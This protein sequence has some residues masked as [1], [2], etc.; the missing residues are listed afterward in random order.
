LEDSEKEGYTDF[1]HW[2]P[3]GD[4]FAIANKMMFVNTILRR[5]CIRKSCKTFSWFEDTLI[6]AGFEKNGTETNAGCH[7]YSHQHFVRGQIKK[8]NLIE[9]SI[10]YEKVTNK[11]RKNFHNTNAITSADTTT[12]ER[13]R[14][15]SPSSQSETLLSSSE[16]EDFDSP[17]VISAPP[18]VGTFSIVNDEKPSAAENLMT[19]VNKNKPRRLK[20]SSDAPPVGMKLSPR[21]TNAVWCSQEHKVVVVSD[22]LNKLSREKNTTPR[23]LRTRHISTSLL[24]KLIAVKKISA[25]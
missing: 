7:Q 1:I 24:D 5:K 21:R 12:N 19:G 13:V 2:L 25:K 14:I 10:D 6:W 8:L 23:E 3:S 20:R 17:H 15:S 18:S 11:A 4:S 9:P 16:S 22:V